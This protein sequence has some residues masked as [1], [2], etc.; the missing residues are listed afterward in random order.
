MASRRHS[1]IQKGR[2][3]VVMWPSIDWG[4]VSFPWI[5]V[6]LCPSGVS[7]AGASHHWASEIS[8]YLR[9]CRCPCGYHK[10][11]YN[12]H[13]ILLGCC[14]QFRIWQQR[15]GDT[16]KYLVLIELAWDDIENPRLEV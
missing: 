4:C 16:V 1:S 11:L 12:I 9:S 8:G 14:L 15:R 13:T 10:M 7:R 2:C 5:G 3:L 6:L